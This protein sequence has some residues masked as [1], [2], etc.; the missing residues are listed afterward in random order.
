M[1]TV[2]SSLAVWDTFAMPETPTLHLEGF[3]TL[4]GLNTGRWTNGYRAAG[5]TADLWCPSATSST[6]RSTGA[7]TVS[8]GATGDILG[9]YLIRDVADG[10]TVEYVSQVTSLPNTP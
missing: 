8:F 9:E 3:G 4:A 10:W 1:A 2:A 7:A 6:L 5:L